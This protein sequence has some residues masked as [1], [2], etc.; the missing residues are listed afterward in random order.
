M[1]ICREPFK[2]VHE[3]PERLRVRANILKDPALDTGY[4][5]ALLLALPGIEQVRINLKSSS[6]SIRHDGDQGV[7]ARVIETLN[8]LPREIWG[9]ENGNQ[10]RMDGMSVVSFAL[11][12]LMTPFLPRPV[13]SLLSWLIGAPTIVKGL[14]TLVSRGVKIEV[15][16]GAAVAFSLMRRDRVTANAIVTLLA[17]SEYIQARSEYRSTGLL[18]KLLKPQIDTVWIDRDGVEVQVSPDTLSIGDRVICGPGDTIPVDGRVIEGRAAINQSSITGESRP[19]RAESGMPV[20]SGSVVMEGRIIIKSDRVG[21]ETALARVGRFLELS[22]R[23]QSES[24]RKAGQVA[25]QLV[26]VTFGTGLGLYALTGDLRR[27]ASALTVDYA[28]PVKLATPVAVR[29]SMYRAAREGVLLKGAQALEALSR[30]DTLVFDKTGTLTTGHLQVTDV[31]PMDSLGAEDL[32]GLAAAAEE[33]Y[34]HPVARAVVREAEI[35]G[36]SRPPIS[37]VDFIVAHGVSAYVD[38]RRILVGNHHFIAEDEG[39]DCRE[40]NGAADTLRKQGRSI[41]YIAREETLLGLVALSDEIRPESDRTIA[42]LK[43]M[44]ID[45]I[46]VLTGDHRQTARRLAES[47][48]HIDEIHWELTPEG[49][50][51]IVR[52][53]K[54]NGRFMAF[55][56]DGV[57]DAP[58]LVTAQVG[59]CLSE[60]ADLAREAAQVVLLK[61]GLEGLVTAREIARSTQKTISRNVYAAVGMNTAILVMAALG[62]LSPLAAAALHNLTTTGIMAR[63]ALAG[64]GRPEIVTS[65]EDRDREERV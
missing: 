32:L 34:R 10:D 62:G 25:D 2:I 12:T 39:I 60:G 15:L 27:S 38:G 17:L 8:N 36:L 61:D 28:C 59:I 42:Q 48:P 3:L 7:K 30:V 51:D 37:Q 64:R 20:I 21:R 58:A 54:D 31:V 16:D 13:G 24:Q 52:K 6:V 23:N 50:A 41:L 63:S 49:K 35:R 53:L 56:G 19:V 29:T 45:R 65:A 43:Q 22:L 11:L 57:N 55:I 5:E 44:G 47:L 1:G 14:E 46:V 4:L 33:H 9:A 26:P 40:A 18:K